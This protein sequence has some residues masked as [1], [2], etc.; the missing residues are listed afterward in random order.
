VS[1]RPDDDPGKRPR[2]RRG[3]VFR[4]LGLAALLLAGLVAI[5]VI[6][7]R[8]VGM[9]TRI[10]GL[11]DAAKPWLYAAQLLCTAIVWLRWPRIIDWLA[12]TGRIGVSA[13]QPLMRARHR[14]MALVLLTQLLVGMGLPFSLFGA[15]AGQ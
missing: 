7:L 3:R 14:L 13:V 1:G 9:V 11:L 5:G 2:P 12:R 15:S 4:A 6:G 8:S 10:E